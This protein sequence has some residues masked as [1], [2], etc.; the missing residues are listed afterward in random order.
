M[1]RTPTRT[2]RLA[3]WLALAVGVVVVATACGIPN[4]GQ[5]RDVAEG[6]QLQLTDQKAPSQAASSVG[7]KV[8]FLSQ[9]PD[10][11]DRLQPAGRN[12]TS[13]ATAVLTE[14]FNG[15]TKEEQQTAPVAYRHPRRH[16]AHLGDAGPDGTLAI[17]LNQAFFQATSDAQ[18]KA[19]AQIVFTATGIDGVQ[20]VKILVEGQPQGWL[21]GDGTAQPVGEPLTAVRL[22]RAEPYEPAGLP[23]GTVADDVV[24]IDD[25]RSELS[26]S[27]SACR[28]S[29]V[30]SPRPRHERREPADEQPG[31]G[32]PTRRRWRRRSGRRSAWCRGTRSPAAPAPGPAWRDRPASAR[33]PSTP[34]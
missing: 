31:S 5:P 22:P 9:G 3:R 2:T 30:D 21:R 8:Y 24:D 25:S 15:L 13:T 27:R 18:I 6:E 28:R 7:P 23:A 26:W 17:D 12:V 1:T 29:G 4:D 10:G 19:V 16:E 20:R 34:S 14:L 32:V 33:W 11:Q